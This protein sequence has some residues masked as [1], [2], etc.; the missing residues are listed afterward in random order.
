[1]K[2]KLSLLLLIAI[3]LVFY[4]NASFTE[5]EAE[6]AL[7]DAL[8]DAIVEATTASTAGPIKG[9]HVT[10]PFGKAGSWSCGKHT[11]ED[12]AAPVG[13]GGTC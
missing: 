5:A 12:Y 10:T 7:I 8:A 6:D 13:T 3:A 2:S 11:G 4:A 9:G 1:M